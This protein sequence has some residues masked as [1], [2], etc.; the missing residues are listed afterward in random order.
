MDNLKKQKF[1]NVTCREYRHLF[2]L[3]YWVVYILAFFIIER[4]FVLN[5]NNIECALD[6]KIPFC[7]FF[8]VP[9]VAWYAF[10]VWIHLYT[11]I[12]DVSAFKKL[13]YFIMITYTV[14]TI[15]Y[16]I[17][18]NMQTLRPTEFE[19]DN[20]FVDIMK[21]IYIIDTNTNVCPSLHVIGSLAVLFT[22][23]SCERLKKSYIRLLL[24]AIT[25]II[26]ASTVLLKQHSI[27]DVVAGLALS[28]AVWPFVYVIPKKK[29]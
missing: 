18:P 28:F 1:P 15:I 26:C 10:L 20:I 7:E 24:V 9:Y 23:W 29:K 4:A 19:R 3:L 21:Y 25:A 6:Y 8:V 5:Y 11:L 14:T 17:Y 22:G 12:F 2:L 13:M 16:L 27:I